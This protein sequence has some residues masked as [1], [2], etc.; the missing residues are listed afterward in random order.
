MNGIFHRTR[1]KNLKIFMETQKTL[2]SQSNPVKEKWSWRKQ[3]PDFRLYYKATVIKI[4]WCWHRNRNID[5]WNR[6][7]NSEINPSTYSQLNYD[8]GDKSKQWR[9]DRH[10]NKWSWENWRS[11]CK[12]MKL[13]HSLTPHTKINS[14]KYNILKMD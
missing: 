4:V 1:T 8:N 7:E 12:R 14:K 11:T 6:I 2:N 10:F 3:A 9:K 5:Q 13:D